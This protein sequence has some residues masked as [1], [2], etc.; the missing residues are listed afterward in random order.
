MND[1][2]QNVQSKRNDAIDSGV[3]FIVSF[4]FFA[5]LF[6]IATVIKFIGS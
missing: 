5:T 1:F 4:G 3:G 6:I 2:E